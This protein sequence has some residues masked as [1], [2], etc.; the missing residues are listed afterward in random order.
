[1]GPGLTINQLLA[2]V[3]TGGLTAVLLIAIW[4]GLN[5]TVVPGDVMRA[6]QMERTAYLQQLLRYQ[7]PVPNVLHPSEQFG[8]GSPQL[9]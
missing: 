7:L 6:C 2:A 3:N 1:M 9:R 4:L 8:P 5:G